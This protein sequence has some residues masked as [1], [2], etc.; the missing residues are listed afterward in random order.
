MQDDGRRV[1]YV[2]TLSRQRGGEY[3]GCWMT[4]GVTRE[5]EQI[6]GTTRV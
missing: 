3:D 6:N 2:F 1:T 5:R 4:D